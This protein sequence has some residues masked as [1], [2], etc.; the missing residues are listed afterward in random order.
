MDQAHGI[1][2]LLRG[3][4]DSGRATSHCNADASALGA[5]VQLA[6]MVL[7]DPPKLQIGFASTDVQVHGAVPAQWVQFRNA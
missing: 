2:A 4:V 3:A 1:A 5:H 7:T 6:D